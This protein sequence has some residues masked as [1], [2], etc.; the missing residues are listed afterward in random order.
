[1]ESLDGVC[2]WRFGLIKNEATGEFSIKTDIADAVR[3][4]H[5]VCPLCGGELVARKGD[6]RND[7][8]AHING[9]KCDAWYEP[10]G[11][12]HRCWQGRFPKEWQEVGISRE[13]SEPERHIAD[14]KT[15]DDWVIEFQYSHIDT[16]DIGRREQFY[17]NMVWV[18]SGTRRVYD[19]PRADL[20]LNRSFVSED[21]P[22]PY[23]SFSPNPFYDEPGFFSRYWMDRDKLVFFD[24]EGTFDKP[25]SENDLYC[26]LPGL[27]ERQRIVVRVPQKDFVEGF[28][29]GRAQEFVDKLNACRAH[30]SEQCRL[31]ALQVEEEKK[32]LAEEEQRRKERVRQSELANPVRYA[33]TC[34]WVEG[35]LYV[36]GLMDSA[37]GVQVAGIPETGKIAIH[38]K[39]EYSEEEYKKDRQRA[40]EMTGHIGVLWRDFPQYQHLSKYRGEVVASGWFEKV[41]SDSEWAIRFHDL[42]RLKTMNDGIRV[43]HDIPDGDG[44]WLLTAEQSIAVSDRA[45]REPP[46]ERK[47][48]L[49]RAVPKAPRESAMVYTGKGNLYRDSKTGWL[50]ILR[51]NGFIPLSREHQNW[52]KTYDAKFGRRRN[53]W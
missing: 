15:S 51:G 23:V 53:W 3:A 10:K 9:R 36:H 42:Q 1:M 33:I 29:S 4:Q 37:I 50:H 38:L 47:K 16:A 28:K 18:V 45:Y 7:H 20:L 17:G 32:R 11:E 48:P 13:G 34:G 26:L 19:K 46:R 52:D 21:V 39:N 31:A 41:W 40:M 30:C 24:F 14:I 8:W 49:G 25:S 2:T 6:Q 27:V 5:G 44:V 43:V 12:W 35:W 22:F